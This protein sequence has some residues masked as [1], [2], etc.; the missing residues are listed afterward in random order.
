MDNMA[1]TSPG[2]ILL[3]GA[4]GKGHVK[5]NAE[6][7]RNKGLNVVALVDKEYSSEIENCC[8]KVIR[9]PNIFDPLINL[10]LFKTELEEEFYPTALGNIQDTIWVSVVNLARELGLKNYDLDTQ[11]TVRLKSVMREIL[12]RNNISPIPYNII[13]DP[14][15]YHLILKTADFPCVIKPISGAGSENVRIVRNK[16]DL[17]GS[18]S[19][20]F[21]NLKIKRDSF[22]DISIH[23]RNT[24]YDICRSLLV[25]KYING[26]EY[27]VEGIVNEGNVHVLTIHEK[28]RLLEK[29]G[30]VL[31]QEYLSPP[32]NIS[33][34][35]QIEKRTVESITALK[36]K[37]TVFHA[38]VRFDGKNVY[39]IEIN[40]RVGGGYINDSVLLKTGVSLR[41]CALQQAIGEP[42][43]LNIKKDDSATMYLIVSTNIQGRIKS[44]SGIDEVKLMPQVKKTKFYYKVGDVLGPFEAELDIMDIFM[45]AANRDELTKAARNIWETVKVE[46][47]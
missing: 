46:V 18:L 33:V 17:Q 34:A 31:D 39:I 37:D 5:E 15:Q 19:R 22:F 26:T 43:R 24:N 16:N 41:E 20:A 13:T 7:L 8:N 3:T 6:Y 38:E 47:E 1:N 2:T 9:S 29:E 30:L 27:S 21:D 23:W 11:C 36:I 35:Q 44:I 12:N 4:F 32:L 10:Q 42:I 40:P 14:K 28:T 25:E 45:N